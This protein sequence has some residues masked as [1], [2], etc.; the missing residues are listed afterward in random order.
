[1]KRHGLILAAAAA[2]VGLGAAASPGGLGVGAPSTSIVS[3]QLAAARRES[4]TRNLRAGDRFCKP[5]PGWTQA[6]VQRMARKKRNQARNR[7]AHR[8]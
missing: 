6:Q 8:G 4:R 1:M 3:P 2:F 7:K 5:G